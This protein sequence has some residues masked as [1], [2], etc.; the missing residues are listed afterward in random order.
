[1]QMSLSLLSSI[2]WQD[3]ID[4]VLN[5]Y[6]LFRF[7]ILFRGTY[8]FRVLSVIAFLWF[9]QNIAVAMGLIVTSW[10]LRGITTVA[11]LIIIVVFRNEIRTILQ[12]TNLR[13]VLWG[14]PGKAVKTPCAVITDTVFELAQKRIGAL[15][16]LPG[17]DNLKEVVQ[18]GLSWRGQ[19]SREMLISIFWPDN[20]VHDGAAIINGGQV[21]EVG[22]ILPLS[23]RK[24]LP[25][26]YGTRHRAASGLSETTDALVIVVS[27]ERGTVVVAKNGHMRVVYEKEALFDTLKEHIGVIAKKRSE[28]IKEN[29][30]I[31]LAGFLSFLFISGVWFSFTRG[32]DTLITLDAPIEYINRKPGMEIVE[33]SD[34]NVQIHLSG[35]NA[36]IRTIRPGQV[37]AR[38]D[39]SNTKVGENTLE[40]GS[41]NIVLPPGVHL[42]RVIPPSIDL[43]LD[44]TI[45]REVPVQINWAGKLDDRLILESAKLLPKKIKLTGRSM[46]LQGIT[47]IY[48]EKV[49]LEQISQSGKIS[50]GLDIP[51]TGVSVAAD[52]PDKIAVEYSVKDRFSR[53]EETTESAA[54]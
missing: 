24:D 3:V 4:I 31:V 45:T 11:A 23:I 53:S 26:Y 51:Y 36:L 12:A 54:R 49:G 18:P 42:E 20:P 29:M 8:A 32:T 21:A 38:L 27:E 17:K 52:S 50:V 5:S 2:R 44:I 33:T 47:T 25:S 7:Y 19:V 6:I 37:Q 34:H 46:A 16:V 14:L 13:G 48:S 10:A 9:F 35:S 1:M 15:I 30:E 39:L 28:K 41:E 22:V 40:L 43:T